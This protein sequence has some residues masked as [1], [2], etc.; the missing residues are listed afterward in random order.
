MF[1][2]AIIAAG[3]RGLRFG[4]TE[5]KQLTMVGGRAVL[6]RSVTAFAT[7]PD[8]DE[9]I[10]ALPAD[11]VDNP[12]EYLRAARSVRIVAGGARRQDS[13]ANAFRAAGAAT[14]LIVIHDAARPFV[15][16]ALIA[17]TIQAAAEA[18]AAVAALQ[19][20]DTVK[21]ADTRA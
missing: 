11:L 14:D 12:P 15:S 8:I 9:V 4:G 5:L 18:G 10:V 2:T 19:A 1:V 21:R 20:R 7:H 17:R 3:G 6:D 16:G 13:V